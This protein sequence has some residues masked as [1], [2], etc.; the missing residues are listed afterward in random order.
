MSTL[1][2]ITI[3]TP[4]YNQADYL[5][6]TMRSVLDQGYPNLEYIV[7][8]GGSTDGSVE[9]IR[10]YADRLAWWVSEKDQGQTD[11]INK[12]FARATG[13]VLGFIN[14]DDLLTSGSLAHVGKAFSEGHRWLVGWST[15]IDATGLDWPFVIG[16]T[17]DPVDWFIANPIPQQSSFWSAETHRKLG[18]LDTGYRFAFDYEWWMRLRFVG[19]L[20]PHIIR[21][22]LGK[23]RLHD[24]SKTTQFADFNNAFEP[25]DHAIRLSYLQYLSPRDRLRFRWQYHQSNAKK[26]LLRGWIALNRKDVPAARKH[27]WERA[28]RKPVSIDSWRLLYCSLRGR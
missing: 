8:D 9:I 20:T 25:E 22:P 11:A 7:C 24:Q 27:A 14:S 12:G 13:E 10:K 23:F 5:E 26:A 28:V 6:E 1:P 16:K 19:G 21:R 18:Q 4:S 3:V 17:D 2:R 15:Y